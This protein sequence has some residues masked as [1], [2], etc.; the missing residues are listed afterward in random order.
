MTNHFGTRGQRRI[1]GSI[2]GLGIA[3]ALTLV[4]GTDAATAVGPAAP[5]ANQYKTHITKADNAVARAI[6]KIHAHQYSRARRDLSSAR[7]HIKKANSGA[8]SLIGKPPTDPES[9]DLPGP[10]AVL[11]AL[12]LDNRVVTRV[13]PL[14]HR[15]N[16]P[17]MLD[18]LRSTVGVT[19]NLR[20]TVLNKVTALPAE[21]DGDDYADGMADTL[22]MYTRE[23]GVISHAR[24]TFRLSP[25]GKV[26][27]TAA[28]RRARAAEAT[29]NAAYGGGERPASPRWSAR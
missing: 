6:R 29:M 18:A 14:F 7:G 5:A 28:L 15:M 10:P 8:M 26:G 3:V 2:V 25:S 17:Q 20:T 16:R 13:V 23:V 19:Q 11:A 21:G 4:P 24:E 27:L 12:R 22:P 1:S 9:D